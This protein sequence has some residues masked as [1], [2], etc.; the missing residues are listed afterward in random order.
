MDAEA[1]LSVA[2]LEAYDEVQIVELST[3]HGTILHPEATVEWREWLSLAG[4]FSGW[5][6]LIRTILKNGGL[7]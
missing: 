5:L 7:R 1:C 3:H 4:D 6:Y 2:E